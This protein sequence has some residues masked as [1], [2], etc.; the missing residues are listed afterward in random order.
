MKARAKVAGRCLEK[1]AFDQ[2]ISHKLSVPAAFEN[3][4]SSETEKEDVTHRRLR[5]MT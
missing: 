3:I 5:V 2:R 1:G 4:L